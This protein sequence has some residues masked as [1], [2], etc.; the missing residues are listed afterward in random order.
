MKTK[1]ELKNEYKQMKPVMGVF[2]IKSSVNNRV[3][4]DISIDMLSKWNRHKM[5]L[6]FGNHR[7]RGLQQ[8]WN[9]HGEDNFVF[10]ILSELKYK[11]ET[12]VNYNKELKVLK[13]LSVEQFN[14]E[15]A[16]IYK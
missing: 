7:N 13:E 5:E 2:Q 6:K 9:E 16:L 10:E 8:D 3:M 12:D 1:K 11:D 4:I 14:I 15:E